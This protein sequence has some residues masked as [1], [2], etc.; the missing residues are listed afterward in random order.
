M[1]IVYNYFFYSGKTLQRSRVYKMSLHMSSSNKRRVTALSPIS[2]SFPCF[3]QKLTSFMLQTYPPR[4]DL[5]TNTMFLPFIY[6]FPI[7]ILSHALT[8]LGL[9]SKRTNVNIVKHMS[10]LLE[11]VYLSKSEEAF[12]CLMNTNGQ[13]ANCYSKILID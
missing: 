6:T 3:S 13:V 5:Q 7:Y 11:N 12:Q 9:Q 10:K 2:R 1:R 8:S 4:R